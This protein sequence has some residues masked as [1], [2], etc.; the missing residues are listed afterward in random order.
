MSTPENTPNKTQQDYTKKAHKL[1]AEG[2]DKTQAYPTD[3]TADL[4][5][6]PIEHLDQAPSGALDDVGDKPARERSRER[7]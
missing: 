6:H 4:G 1:K 5:M 2:A 3:Q 7:R